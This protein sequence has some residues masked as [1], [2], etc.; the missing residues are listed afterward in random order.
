ML[1]QPRCATSFDPVR[2]TF[3]S[4]SLPP[5][6]APETVDAAHCTCRIIHTIFSTLFRSCCGCC[7][8][9]CCSG[10][11]STRIKAAIFLAPTQWPL[12]VVVV[13]CCCC[14]LQQCDIK[15]RTRK[16]YHQR[17]A[18][19]AATTTITTAKAATINNSISCC[20]HFGFENLCNLKAVKL[21]I[22]AWHHAQA[23]TDSQ[24]QA[25]THTHTHTHARTAGGRRHIN[26]CLLADFFVHVVADA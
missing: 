23:H 7:C 1:G 15:Q 8:C 13:G 26:I 16:A 14:I 19:W 3:A 21:R 25:H 17:M 24:T 20:W 10:L 5:W 11:I 9:W 12:P 6:T 22:Y 4:A 18:S 2:A